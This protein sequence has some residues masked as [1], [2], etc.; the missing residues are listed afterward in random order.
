MILRPSPVLGTTFLTISAGVALL[1]SWTSVL[2]TVVPAP[3]ALPDLRDTATGQE[4]TRPDTLPVPRPAVFYAAI[5]QR[6]L[7]APSRRPG[8]PLADAALPDITSTDPVVSVVPPAPAPSIT[9]KGTALTRD[10]WTAL[11]GT[12]DQPAKWVSLGGT[13]YGFTLVAVGP[14]WAELTSE[15]SDLK[16]ELYPR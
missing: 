2:G 6:P 13:L 10:G 15:T 7:F 14:D 11:I 5:T 8:K 12:E 3:P 16:L 1:W 4:T 9:L